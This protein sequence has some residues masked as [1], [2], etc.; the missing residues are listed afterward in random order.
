MQEKIKRIVSSFHHSVKATDKLGEVQETNGG[1]RKKLIMDVETRWNSTHYMMERYMEQHEKVTTTL[2]LLGKANM[3]L[4]SEHL[5]VVNSVVSLLEPFEEAT[6]EMSTEK[7]TSLSKIIPVSRALQECVK[8]Q[9]V[10]ENNNVQAQGTSVGLRAE[11]QKQLQKRFPYAEKMFNVGDA[12]LLDPW[13]KKVPFVDQSNTKFIEDRLV[14]MM[15]TGY[16]LETQSVSPAVPDVPSAEAEPMKC[17]KK[18]PPRKVSLWNSFDAKVERC[19]KASH[20][21]LTGPHIE[22]RRYSTLKNLFY[23]GK[24]IHSSGGSCTLLFSPSSRSVLKI[25]YV[26]QRYQFPQ[27]HSSLKQE[28]WCRRNAAPC[29]MTTST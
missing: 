24:K 13:F 6:R 15:R 4:G 23:Q 12:T 3:C 7:F 29:V 11:L 16:N 26:F 14:N 9:P 1:E 8:S 21:T 18:D 20:S 10:S 25:C 28:N 19:K 27:R 17:T 5:D 2:C 22:M